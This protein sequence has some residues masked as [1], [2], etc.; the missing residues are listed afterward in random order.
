MSEAVPVDPSQTQPHEMSSAQAAQEYGRHS[1]EHTIAQIARISE[2]LLNRGQEALDQS[3]DTTENKGALSKVSSSPNAELL[4]GSGIEIH[5]DGKKDTRFI[6]TNPEG[7]PSHALFTTASVNRQDGSTENETQHATSYTLST[8]KLISDNGGEHGHKS[9]E[10]KV[11][12][13]TSDP[14]IPRVSATANSVVRE[15]KFSKEARPIT[16]LP[17]QRKVAGRTLGK[18]RGAVAQQERAA[19]AADD[20]QTRITTKEKDDVDS[21]FEDVK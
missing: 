21:F 1:E 13:G 2:G 19:Q 20:E 4:A 3:P 10:V 7:S 8:K 9:I 6:V 17:A 16:T 15:P 12:D 11:D 5:Q 14:S 18:I